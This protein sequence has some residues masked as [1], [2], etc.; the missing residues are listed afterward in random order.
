MRF[1]SNLPSPYLKTSLTLNLYESI[2]QT[3][4]IFI[5]EPQFFI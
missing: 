3:Q 5:G 4:E 2:E 1:I